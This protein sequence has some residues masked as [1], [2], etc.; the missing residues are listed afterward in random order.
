[1]KVRRAWGCKLDIFHN[2]AVSKS[3]IT[4]TIVTARAALYVI[5]ALPL[6]EGFGSSFISCPESAWIS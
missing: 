5:L 1:M 4:E 6:F 2:N 3:T